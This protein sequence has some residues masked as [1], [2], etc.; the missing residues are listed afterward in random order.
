MTS[1]LLANVLATLI[2]A[3]P[4]SMQA[5]QQKK[6]YRVSYLSPRLGIE[7]REEALRQSLRDLGY[8]E[9]QNLAIDWRFSKGNS[10]LIPELR[11]RVV[12]VRDPIV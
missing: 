4:G 2:L 3:F 8:V 1:R 11:S 10:D 12:S 9:G 6:A 7:P 5:Q